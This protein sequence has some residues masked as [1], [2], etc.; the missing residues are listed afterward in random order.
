MNTVRTITWLTFHEARRRRMVLVAL[1]LGAL[2]LALYAAGFWLIEVKS[3]DEAVEW[4]KRVP[5]DPG[6]EGQIEIRR[7]YERDDFGDEYSDEARERADRVWEQVKD[8]G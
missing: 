4:M 2:F 1:V 7:V 5:C 3:L 8:R 6:D